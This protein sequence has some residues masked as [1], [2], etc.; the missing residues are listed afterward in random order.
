M[1]SAAHCLRL[2]LPVDTSPSKNGIRS[3]QHLVPVYFLHLACTL[4]THHFG[5]EIDCASARIR[6]PLT[7]LF[8]S[9]LLPRGV[10]GLME[11]KQRRIKFGEENKVKMML[12][13]SF[14]DV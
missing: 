12:Q 4:T 7:N 2:Q 14:S 10:L 6:S 8:T 1:V 3:V 5:S 13:S 9:Y 11:P